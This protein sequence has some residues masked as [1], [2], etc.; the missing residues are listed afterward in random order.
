MC[1]QFQDN[2]KVQMDFNNL[3][4]E[5]KNNPIKDKKEKRVKSE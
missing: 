2:V 5:C 1:F 4:N 3:Y